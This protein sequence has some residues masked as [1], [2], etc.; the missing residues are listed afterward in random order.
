MI[1]IIINVSFNLS[2]Y[3]MK[4]FFGMEKYIN[5]ML[6]ETSDGTANLRITIISLTLIVSIFV[7][8]L[9]IRLTKKLLSI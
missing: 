7:Y 6:P 4:L 3:L 1:T 8:H 9:K 2:A 5:D